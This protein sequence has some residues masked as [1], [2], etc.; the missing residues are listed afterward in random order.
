MD[1]DF[2][3]LHCPFKEVTGLPCPFCGGTRAFIQA[4]QLHSE[5][6]HYNAVWVFVA[7]LG[8]AAAMTALAMRELSP[9]RF[10]VVKRAVEQTSSRTRLTAVLIVIA[11]AWAWAIAHSS[12]IVN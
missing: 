8:V 3:E 2:V 4:A 10:A 5:F 1:L 12:T 9:A 11:I 7:V 6:L